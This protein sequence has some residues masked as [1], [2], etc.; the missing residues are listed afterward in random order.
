MCGLRKFSLVS[1]GGQFWQSGGGVV[2]R[3][4]GRGRSGRGQV[5]QALLTDAGRAG[6]PRHAWRRRAG[7]RNT[8]RG[9]ARR[10]VG[11]ARR[12]GEVPEETASWRRLHVHR[13]V[14]EDLRRSLWNWR[15]CVR[16]GIAGQRGRGAR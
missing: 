11:S 3:R 5:D 16:Q 2:P 4:Y 15:R 14:D 6:A 10:G 9:R 1:L 8:G 7:G 12:A 13:V